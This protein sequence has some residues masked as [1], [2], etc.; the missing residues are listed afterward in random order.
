MGV[1]EVRELRQLSEENTRLMFL[2]TKSNLEIVSDFPSFS[3][4]KSDLF[5]FP[6]RH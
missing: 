3:A 4:P 6:T 2:L 5:G 1:P